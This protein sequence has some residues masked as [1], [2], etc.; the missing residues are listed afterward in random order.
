[1]GI[2]QLLR[3]SSYEVITNILITEIQFIEVG[4]ES[5]ELQESILLQHLIRVGVSLN[6]LIQ[7]IDLGSLLMWVEFLEVT[8]LDDEV[9]Q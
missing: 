1:L 8:Q 7:H 4:T 6:D 3:Q 2:T 9:T 5:E